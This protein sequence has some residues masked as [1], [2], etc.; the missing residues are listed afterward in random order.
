MYS[1]TNVNEFRSGFACEIVMVVD[2]L[3]VSSTRRDNGTRSGPTTLHCYYSYL[4]L[5]KTYQLT[6]YKTKYPW[7]KHIDITP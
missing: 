3:R 6:I 5:S 4:T 2:T 7:I 1:V